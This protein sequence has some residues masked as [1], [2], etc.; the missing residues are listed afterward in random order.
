MNPTTC[1]RMYVKRDGSS[2]VRWDLVLDNRLVLHLHE[3]RASIC[4]CFF[5]PH[6]IPEADN[7]GSTQSKIP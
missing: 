6:I 2:V 7:K 4:S 3:Q 1:T 5:A